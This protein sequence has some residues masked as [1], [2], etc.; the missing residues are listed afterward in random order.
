LGFDRSTTSA[1]PR[2]AVLMQRNTVL[3]GQHR[4]LRWLPGLCRCLDPGDGGDRHRCRAESPAAGG[5]LD[6]V[7]SAVERASLW[8]RMAMAPEVCWDRLLS[9]AKGSVHK[10]WFPLTGRP[11]RFRDVAIVADPAGSRFTVRLL[12]PGPCGRRPLAIWAGGGLAG[13]QRAGHHGG[14]GR[15]LSSPQP[16][17]GE[18]AAAAAERSG[19]VGRAQ[20]RGRGTPRSASGRGPWMRRCAGSMAR[21]LMLASRRFIRPSSVNS[22][23]SLP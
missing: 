11:L 1:P 7:A 15:G 22:H 18:F 20:R 3:G 6:A 13:Q 8:E 19:R 17:G 4:S 14:R 23:S 10:A 21:S 2:C 12:I 9:S 16:T 5:L